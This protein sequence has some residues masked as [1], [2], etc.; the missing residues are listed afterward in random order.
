MYTAKI[1]V[2]SNNKVH[3]YSLY[4]DAL[5]LSFR[6]VLSAWQSN[7]IFRTFYTQV[8]QNAMFPAFFWEHPS[9]SENSI[10][11]NYEFVLVNS[12][13]LTAVTAQP[14]VFKAHFNQNDIVQFANISG[15]A[16]LIVPCPKSTAQHYTHLANFIRQAPIPQ[17]HSL[18]QKTALACQEQ[19][20]NTP[21]WLSTA[22]LGVYWLHLRIDQR[23]KYYRHLAY[24]NR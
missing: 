16:Q 24:K 9:F 21:Q 4:N 22:G 14:L 12:T 19:L 3:R 15:T 13:T 17:I 7:P 1:E 10:D 6:Q 11:N 8:L 20:S 2:L 23:P 18:W 5:P